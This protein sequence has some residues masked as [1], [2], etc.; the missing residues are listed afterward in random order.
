MQGSG[1]LPLGRQVGTSPHLAIWDYRLRWH[2]M[3][4]ACRLRT[5]R[6]SRVIAHE[7]GHAVHRQLMT[8]NGVAPSYATGQ[9]QPLRRAPF[10]IFAADVRSRRTESGGLHEKRRLDS[11]RSMCLR[12][13]SQRSS[14]E[15]R[16][17]H[18]HHFRE[19]RGNSCSHRSACWSA[20]NK[21]LFWIQTADTIYVLGP[22]L[23]KSQLLNVTLHGSTKVALDGNNA[24][25]LD[26]YGK[27]KKMPV[28]EKVARPKP[29]EPQ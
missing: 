10:G 8:A 27:D 3:R 24:H 17:G 9:T 1:K 19:T 5:P 12:S 13:T 7:G 26:D 22:V 11:C 28:F 29:E 6:G 14:V 23:T 21:D 4:S 20:Y 15:R 18:R 16:E 25:I 2:P